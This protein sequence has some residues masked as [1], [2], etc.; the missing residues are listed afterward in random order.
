MYSRMAGTGSLSASNGMK[1]RAAKRV[2]SESGIQH[3][4]VSR[5]SRRRGA[6]TDITNSDFG[7]STAQELT[8][9]G[10][11]DRGLRAFEPLHVDVVGRQDL[12]L[13]EIAVDDIRRPE[14]DPDIGRLVFHDLLHADVHLRPLRRVR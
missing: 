14:R 2:P 6:P 10:C 8:L 9:L 5:T 3:S 4:S 7:R 1:S 12:R 13:Q 11:L